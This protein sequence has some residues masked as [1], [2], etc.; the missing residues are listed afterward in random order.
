METMKQRLDALA[1]G[2]FME[3]GWQSF[4]KEV[5]PEIEDPFTEKL[6]FM[7][8]IQ[9]VVATFEGRLSAEQVALLKAECTAYDKQVREDYER[10]ALI[11][12][13]QRP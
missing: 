4:Y 2:K 3:T 5:M 6:A 9:W 11:E 10:K 12:S 7:S 1:K 8:G 13:R